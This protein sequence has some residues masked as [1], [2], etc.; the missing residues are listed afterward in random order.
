MHLMFCD[1]CQKYTMK[2]CGFLL[3]SHFSVARNPNAHSCG[4][5]FVLDKTEGM[6]VHWAAAPDALGSPRALLA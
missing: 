3:S 1:D 6:R 5:V 2:V 4:F